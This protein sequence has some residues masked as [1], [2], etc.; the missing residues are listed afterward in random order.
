M[1]HLLRLLHDEARC[2]LHVDGAHLVRARVR[3]RVRVDGG[4]RRADARRRWLVRVMVRVRAR[5]R[6]TVRVR[7]DG[8][9][10]RA[11]CVPKAAGH[12]RMPCAMHAPCPHGRMPACTGMCTRHAHGTASTY[13]RPHCVHMYTAAWSALRAHTHAQARAVGGTCFARGDYAGALP[14]L[15]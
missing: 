8:G 12:S 11:W 6:I 14:H 2:E 13:T 5:V 7:V 15:T 9:R 3:V 10:R 1:G 4:Q